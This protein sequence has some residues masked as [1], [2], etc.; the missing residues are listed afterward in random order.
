M[1]AYEEIENAWRMLELAQSTTKLSSELDSHPTWLA[2]RASASNPEYIC[3]LPCE[4][5]TAME[6]SPLVATDWYL[7]SNC[8]VVGNKNDHN[9]E[10]PTPSLTT[11]IQPRPGGKQK[12]TQ[13]YTYQRHLKSTLDARETA[14]QTELVSL[15]TQLRAKDPLLADVHINACKDLYRQISHSLEA[16]KVKKNKR[17][18]AAAATYYTLK[19]FFNPSPKEIERIF[20]MDHKSLTDALKRVKDLAFR[21]PTELGWLF[22]QERGE[23]N[24]YRYA[25]REN[26]PWGV[27]Q[28]CRRYAKQKDLDIREDSVVTSLLRKFGQ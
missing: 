2:P 21:N 15:E 24:L 25:S 3:K 26:L 13:K 27:V 1:N 28:K 18:V 14:L 8:G 4:E 16:E 6:E 22:E 20:D 9:E 7:Y 19:R 10:Y 12:S 5:T 11:S 17:K 23:T